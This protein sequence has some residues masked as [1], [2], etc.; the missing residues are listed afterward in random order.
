MK[1]AIRVGGALVAL[2]LVSF[3]G[4]WIA[5]NRRDAGRMSGEVRELHRCAR[6]A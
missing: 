3:L 5:S 4:L 6:E 2:F 1:W